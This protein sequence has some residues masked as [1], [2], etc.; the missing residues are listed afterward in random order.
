MAP[1]SFIYPV[2]KRG[3]P[4]VYL[5]TRQAAYAAEQSAE[6]NQY[7]TPTTTAL[8]EIDPPVTTYFPPGE[9]TIPGE[10]EQL[11]PPLS[12][13]I[14]P[15]D[16]ASDIISPITPDE[17]PSAP[18]SLPTVSVKITVRSPILPR[19]PG[20]P[21]LPHL[22][23][24]PESVG[25]ESPSRS[26]RA[27]ISSTVQ[28]LGR[29]LTDQLY[30][31]HGCCEHCHS[32]QQAEH[33]TQHADHTGLKDYLQRIQ[34]EGRFPDI[35]QVPII[36]KREDNLAGQVSIYIYLTTDHHADTVTEVTFDINIAKQGSSLYLDP[37]P[38]QYWDQHGQSYQVHRP[39]HEI[40]YYTFGR[41]IRFK[42]ISLYIL[43]PRLYREKHSL[44]QYYPSSF[45][46]SQLNSTA[47]PVARQQL[48]FYFLPPKAL[49]LPGQQQFQ[50]LMILIQVQLFQQ[51]WNH[52]SVSAY[53]LDQF[54][55][56]IGKETCPA[57][58]DPARESLYPGNPGPQTV[59]WQRCCLES[60]TEWIGQQQPHRLPCSRFYSSVK[61]VFTAGNVYPFT[62]PT[63]ELL[64]LDPQLHKTWQHVGG[65]LS[66]NP[67]ALIQAYLHM[68]QRCHAALQGSYLKIFG[69]REEHRVSQDLFQAIHIKIHGQDLHRTWI[70]GTPGAVEPF[71]SLLTPTLLFWLYWNINKFC[72]GFKMV[73]SLNNRHFVTWKHTRV[74][75][76]FLRCLQFSYAGGLPQRMSGC[77]RDVWF[78]LDPRQPDGIRRREGLG[79]QRSM[80]QYGYAW[81][82]DKLNW[83]T[84]T[85]RHSFVSYMVFNNPSLQAAYRARYAQIHQWMQEFSAT[86]PCLELLEDLL[87]QLCLCVFW[88]DSHWLLP[89]P[90]SRGF[91]RKSKESGQEYYLPASYYRHYPTEL[92]RHGRGLTPYME[93]AVAPEM[94]LVRLAEKELYEKLL[95]IADHFMYKQSWSPALIIS[96]ELVTALD[97]Y[98]VLQYSCQLRCYPY[99]KHAVSSSPDTAEDEMISDEES[100]ENR[101]N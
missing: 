83:D 90:H 35:L 43:F 70:P 1:Q 101:K 88:K 31:H 32:Q 46:H 60:Y 92:W 34:T 78:Q 94:K 96:Q 11:L 24:G 4:R 3:R 14:L 87:Q 99:R 2:R 9:T 86:L 41:F 38:V 74:I 29:S 40:P 68:K 58:I 91:M 95:Q 93:Y 16:S 50:D 6:F 7:Y 28:A 47:Y 27:E 10:L 15:V 22:H 39:V 20:S 36:A 85:F 26:Y 44:V 49:P 12:P 65:R 76:M 73:Y 61:E 5:S 53:L 13:S 17:E 62:N 33:D 42:D 30:H 54:Y 100:L 98:D 48:L 56:D 55:L 64:A 81:F 59:V 67:V 21:D 71:Y 82:Q 72:V 69:L 25:P 75:L 8:T 57:G 80:D 97:E 66:H 18:A 79:F 45:N 89:Y 19:S 63:L 23:V 77:W 84:M 52:A 51:H 37:L